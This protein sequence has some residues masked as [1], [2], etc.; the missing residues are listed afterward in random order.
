MFCIPY[1]QDIPIKIV[2]LYSV[3][4]DPI[5]CAPQP[6]HQRLLRSKLQ[7]W[8]LLHLTPHPHSALRPPDLHPQGHPGHFGPRQRGVPQGRTSK[9]RVPCDWNRP[10]AFKSILWLG[11]VRRS[12]NSFV[13][14]SC[15]QVGLVLVP[16]MCFC[17]A[18]LSIRLL[19]SVFPVSLFPLPPT[20]LDSCANA[21]LGQGFCA[22]THFLAFMDTL[23]CIHGHTFLHSWTHFLAF[24]EWADDTGSRPAA[25]SYV[26]VQS[27]SCS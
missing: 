20:L 26:P 25:W 27:S 13:N 21:W 16:Q 9:V 19:A 17:F 3:F 5:G 10:L 8:L 23:S 2:T 1:Q 4:P 14:L 7:E 12:S 6:H 18:F 15:V 24:M 22:W 11:E